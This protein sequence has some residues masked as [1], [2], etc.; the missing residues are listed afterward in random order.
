M[1]AFFTQSLGFFMATK[2]PLVISADEAWDM[3]EM[4]LKAEFVTKR[5]LK[6]DMVEAGIDGTTFSLQLQIADSFVL[7]GPP[8]H[9][10]R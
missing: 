8:K 9:R 10:R 5:E 6:Q 7:H 1:S 4:G 2:S 3:N